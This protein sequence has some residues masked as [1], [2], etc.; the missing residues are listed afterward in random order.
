[1]PVYT[2]T[3]TDEPNVS[4]ARRA[5][6]RHQRLSAAALVAVPE[7]AAVARSALG[8]AA[9]SSAR[10]PAAAMSTDA[11]L[12]G[13]LT[14]SMLQGEHGVLRKEFDK[15]VDWIA[16]EPLPDVINLPN[17]LLIA[18]ARAARARARPAGLLHAAGRGAVPRRARE[19]YRERALDADSASR[20]RD[21]DRFIAV[22]EYCAR[23]MSRL[24]W[25]FP[26]DRMAV[27]PLGISMD[28]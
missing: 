4:R 22:S 17:S 6:R 15:L 2:P 27:V 16:D 13:E 10:S 21:V 18:M 25:A 3:R 12:L 1:M 24:F 7:D 5:V 19:P 11:Q 14:I 26:R 28:G 20:S 8:F 23:F 9:A